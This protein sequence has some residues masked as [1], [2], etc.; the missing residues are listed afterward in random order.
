[1]QPR[2]QSGQLGIDAY[3]PGSL[4]ELDHRAVDIQKKRHGCDVDERGL[5]KYLAQHLVLLVGFGLR[6][7]RI[8]H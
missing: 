2:Q 1:M 7:W 6:R 3:R 5:R 8:D 4:R